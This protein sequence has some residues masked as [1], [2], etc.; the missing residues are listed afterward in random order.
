VSGLQRT[1]RDAEALV[2][3]SKRVDGAERHG[4]P[5]GDPVVAGSESE[6]AARV[7]GA[8]HQDPRAGF[9][10]LGQ[11]VAAGLPP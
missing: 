10:A 4:R 3:D 5:T 8:R 6:E 9:V 11:T 2:G 7:G 1:E